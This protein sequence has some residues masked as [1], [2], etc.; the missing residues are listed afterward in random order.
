MVQKPL[1]AA[2][3]EKEYLNMSRPRRSL[4]NAKKEKCEIAAP[5]RTPCQSPPA[6]HVWPKYRAS[7]SM[8]D[9]ALGLTCDPLG[10]GVRYPAQQRDMRAACS[11]YMVHLRPKCRE[12][13]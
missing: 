13:I 8:A 5:K 3:E 4:A 11:G 6:R 10:G 12:L 9:P 2:L 7:N 1:E